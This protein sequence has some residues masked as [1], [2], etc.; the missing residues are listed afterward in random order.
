MTMMTIDYS[1]VSVG[2]CCNLFITHQLTGLLEATWRRS[3][4]GLPA[5][6]S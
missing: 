5:L 2:V 6:T 3:S 1:G 4:E